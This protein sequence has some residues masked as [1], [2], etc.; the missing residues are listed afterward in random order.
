MGSALRTWHVRHS[1]AQACSESTLHVEP[2]CRGVR[3]IAS[4]GPRRRRRTDSAAAPPTG[5][6]VARAWI[7][8]WPSMARRLLLEALGAARLQPPPGLGSGPVPAGRNRGP[9][10][11]DATRP[12][13]GAEVP[14]DTSEPGA[15][16]SSSLRRRTRIRDCRGSRRRPR[17]A[18]GVVHRGPIARCAARACRLSRG[19]VTR[20][21]D[22][23]AWGNAGARREVRRAPEHS[24]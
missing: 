16:V 17:A 13:R 12:R 23:R 3:G 14:R 10:R 4:S 22:A 1:T 7:R 8:S 9:I 20:R 21:A 19:D 18:E 11:G 24:S 15:P 6:L 5:Q 2:A